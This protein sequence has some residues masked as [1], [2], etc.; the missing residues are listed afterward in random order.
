M[1]QFFSNFLNAFSSQLG[2]FAAFN[3]R[4]SFT[5]KWA[6]LEFFLS[7]H[8]TP[9]PSTPDF[10]ASMVPELFCQFFPCPKSAVWLRNATA[11][12][13]GQPKFFQEFR[14]VCCWWSAQ[15]SWDDGLP[16]GVTAALV[17]NL[18]ATLS[19]DWLVFCSWIWSQQL[20]Q[21]TFLP[22][23]FVF[24]KFKLACF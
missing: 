8:K 12:H 5:V 10:I 13:H 17:W 14:S 6:T 23:W 3:D 15:P 9:I 7:S 22:D 1:S 18:T 20:L 21:K 24:Q 11:S 19:S 16:A 4:C 2:C